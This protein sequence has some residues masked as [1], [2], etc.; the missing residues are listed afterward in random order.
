MKKSL[1][2]AGM[3]I[4]LIVSAAAAQS[5]GKIDITIMSCTELVCDNQKDVFLVN[6]GAYIDYNSSVKE[7]TYAATITFPDG[8]K[9][10][11]Q[12]PNRITSNVTGNYT[13]E[14]IAWKEGYEEARASKVVQ[15]VNELPQQENPPVLDWTRFLLFAL[16][17]G[18]TVFVVW[19]IYRRRKRSRT[20]SEKKEE[21]PETSQKKSRTRKS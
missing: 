16:A 3:L 20:V 8:T 13:V 18:L 11:T 2:L 4:L 14:I 9:Y 19:G 5:P 7:I 15:F 17:A 12:F 6:E 1:L 21:K 10:Q